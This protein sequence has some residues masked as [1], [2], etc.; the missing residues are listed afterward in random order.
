[1]KK[2][3]L[4][5]KKSIRMM[6]VKSWENDVLIW[7]WI[8]SCESFMSQMLHV[9]N[10]YLHLP[11]KSPSYV[12]KYTSTMEHLGVIILD[13]IFEN[14]QR[15]SYSSPP[16]DYHELNSGRNSVVFWTTWT[17]H[18]VHPCSSI[19]SWW[20]PKNFYASWSKTSWTKDIWRIE[21]KLED[22]RWAGCCFATT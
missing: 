15:D 5:W 22:G 20:L 14:D 2:H 9:W 8:N 7:F 3:I 6:M 10:I 1:M 16:S 18:G 4:V 11:Q 21:T 19:L 17:H 12:G 13:E